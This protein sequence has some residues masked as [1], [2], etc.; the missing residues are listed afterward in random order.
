MKFHNNKNCPQDD[1]SCSFSHQHVVRYE[2]SENAK[3]ARTMKKTQSKP[4]RQSTAPAFPKEI[5][6]LQKKLMVVCQKD[7]SSSIFHH[8]NCRRRAEYPDNYMTISIGKI[9]TERKDMRP[10]SS[11][12]R[13]CQRELA[14]LMK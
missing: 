10:A 2:A 3:P 7:G 14:A 5:T 12:A 8:P 13:C 4:K 1:G 9:L 6:N 11:R